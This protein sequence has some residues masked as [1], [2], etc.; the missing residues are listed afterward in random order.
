MFLEIRRVLT[1]T[2]SRS[3]GRNILE[4]IVLPLLVAYVMVSAFLARS[5]PDAQGEA[6]LFFGTLYAFWCGLFGSCQAFNGEVNSGEWSYWMLGMHRGIVR[7]YVAH[8]VAA[9][10]FALIQVALSLFFLW[11]LWWIGTVIKPLAYVFITHQ[12]G[13]TFVHQI[14]DLIKGG[15]AFN[16]CGLKAIM[17]HFNSNAKE[18]NLLWFGFCCRYYLVGVIASVVSGVAIGLLISAS[19][20]TPQVSL[21][22]SVFIIVACCIYSH[23]GILGSGSSCSAKD[24]EFAPLSLIVNQRGREFKSANEYESAV[25]RE[26]YQSQTRCKDGGMVELF[27]FLLP[28]R[29]FFNI[30]RIPCLKLDYSLKSGEWYKAERLYE[31]TTNVVDF[32]KCPVCLGVIRVNKVDQDEYIICDGGENSY[33]VTSSWMSCKTA[34]DWKKNNVLDDKVYDD[35]GGSAKFEELIKK[36]VGGIQSLFALCRMMAIGEILALTVWCFIYMVITLVL[37]KRRRMFNELR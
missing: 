22:V 5:A 6:F 26:K 1:T 19:C 12:D 9:L 18:P 17:N 8:F 7:H 28:Q 27:S 13:G 11:L 36:D 23:T 21:S 35:N 33:L 30:V 25:D 31:H 4:F 15:D 2:W 32:C 16:L 20:P 24:R 14:S 37:M 29:Y 3:R 10:L 34:G